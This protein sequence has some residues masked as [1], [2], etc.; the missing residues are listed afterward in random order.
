[1]KKILIGLVVILVL[2]VG[3]LFVV[4]PIIGNSVVKSR[5]V[6]AVKEA[7]GRDLQIADV[8][9]AVLPSVS[10]SITGLRLA[11]AEGASTP[12]MV[13][14]GRMDLDLQLFPLI[15]KKII[16]DRLVISDLAASLE[17]NEAGVPNWAFEGAADDDEPEAADVGEGE[18]APLADLR[19]SDVRLE[20]ARLSYRDMTSGQTIDAGD[21]LAIDLLESG[22]VI[23]V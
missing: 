4:P 16:V 18:G 1:M 6:E 13:S 20:N 7:T 22:P 12:E 15:G 11:N 17:V 3:A 19:L 14:L 5:I 23:V 9:L 8:S 2:I 21:Y 10:I